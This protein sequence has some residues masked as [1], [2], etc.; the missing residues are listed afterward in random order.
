MGMIKGF[1][2]QLEDALLLF[3]NHFWVF[4]RFENRK[5]NFLGL[6]LAKGLFWESLLDPY[7]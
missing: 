1:N 7:N 4:L 3:I 5:R 2:K 6:I